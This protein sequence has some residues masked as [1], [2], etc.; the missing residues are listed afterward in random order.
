MNVLSMFRNLAKKKGII[1]LLVLA[2]LNLSCNYENDSFG[3]NS[4]SYKLGN[5]VNEEDYFK[6]IILFSGTGLLNKIPEYEEIVDDLNTLNEEQLI[7]LNKFRDEIVSNIKIIDSNYFEKFNNSITSKDLYVIQDEIERVGTMVMAA[8]SISEDYS[9]AY[10]EA[11]TIVNDMLEKGIESDEELNKYLGDLEDLYQDQI[12][13]D[14]YQTNAVAIALLLA[15]AIVALLAAAVTHAV[16][17][18]IA[19]VWGGVITKTAVKD[20]ISKSKYSKLTQEKVIKSISK[21]Y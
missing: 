19:A 3:V 12:D 6:E 17:A 18:V 7:E 8:L 5:L 2:F 21:N 9:L 4:V 13:D 16:A 20:V 11:Q 10:A 1:L 14:D 15:V